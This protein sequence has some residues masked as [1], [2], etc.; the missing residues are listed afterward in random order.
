[1]KGNF[2]CGAFIAVPV[3]ICVF[4]LITA[5]STFD[6]PIASGQGWSGPET[7]RNVFP[8]GRVRIGTVKADKGSD[9]NSLE[10]EIGGLLPLLLLERGY[11]PVEGGADYRIDT[12]VIEREYPSGWT[13]KRSL[14]TEIRIWK[15][16]GGAPLAS[17]G[18]AVLSGKK[19]L[20][21][22]K[23]LTR[24]LKLALSK[25]LAGLD[26]SAGPEQK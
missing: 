23:T 12:V 25:A 11:V 7:R 22:S 20:A 14:S 17:A 13:T 5:C 18:R 1:M 9:W 2:T 19:S 4:C 15:E 6:V 26:R 10:R 3:F 21:S 8:G 24:L 16:D